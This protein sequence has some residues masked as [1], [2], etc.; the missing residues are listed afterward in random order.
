[1]QTKMN[2]WNPFTSEILKKDRKII[3]S[4]KDANLMNYNKFLLCNN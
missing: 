2:A 4:K 3:G 1:M